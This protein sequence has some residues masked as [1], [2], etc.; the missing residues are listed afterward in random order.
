MLLCCSEFAESGPN[1][2]QVVH[3]ITGNDLSVG[4]T[5]TSNTINLAVEWDLK[6]Q[7]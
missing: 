5:S 3:L 2:Q 4:S 1:D 6:P 7:L